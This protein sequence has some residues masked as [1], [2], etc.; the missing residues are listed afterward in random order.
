MAK[1][2]NVTTLDDETSTD[3]VQAAPVIATPTAG[4]IDDQLSGERRT[5]T[6]H[7]TGDENEQAVFVSLN[8]Y[9]YQIPRGVPCSVPAEVIEILQNAKQT[10][11]TQTPTGVVE[12]TVQRFPFSVQ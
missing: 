3:V 12:R 4:G 7:Q 2:T 8:G 5:V 11:Y 6:I 10:T 9:A 1:T